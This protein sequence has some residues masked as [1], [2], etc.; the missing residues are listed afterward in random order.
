[1]IKI[2]CKT[3]KGYKHIYKSFRNSYIIVYISGPKYLTTGSS[4]VHQPIAVNFTFLKVRNVRY[5]R[6]NT[7]I[8]LTTIVI[9]ILKQ[10]ELENGESSFTARTTLC[11][12]SLVTFKGLLVTSVDSP[13]LS[14]G[15]KVRINKIYI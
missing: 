3:N 14:A 5:S 11:S 13:L 6:R 15:D 4:S 2:Y 7:L 8:T 12:T 1:M 9:T 10:S